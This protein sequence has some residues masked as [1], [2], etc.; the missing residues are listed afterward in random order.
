MLIIKLILILHTAIMHWLMYICAQMS[1]PVVVDHAAVYIGQL[2]KRLEELEQRKV[3]L[4]AEHSP[5]PPQAVNMRT[6]TTTPVMEITDLGST[7]KVTLISGKDTSFV[8]CDIISILEEEGAQVLSAS[9]HNAGNK[10]FFSIHS[11]V[12]SYS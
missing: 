4:E 8:L 6:G 2:Q 1:I 12:I 5:P 11:Q 10:V 9:Y 3:Q 7:V